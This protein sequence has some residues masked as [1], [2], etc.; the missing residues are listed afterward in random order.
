MPTLSLITYLSPATIAT[1]QSL[2]S[3]DVCEACTAW[4]TERKLHPIPSII[5]K[6]LTSDHCSCEKS[7]DHYYAQ[8]F[9][10]DSL[11]K[12]AVR[13]AF[14]TDGTC[15]PQHGNTICDPNSKA[16][17]VSVSGCAGEGSANNRCTGRMLFCKGMNMV[18]LTSGR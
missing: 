2:A 11:K 7:S 18:S 5:D 15:G 16:Y 12:L 9:Q 17:T 3:Q 4:K 13:A 1:S 10:G 14:S 8:S 6:H